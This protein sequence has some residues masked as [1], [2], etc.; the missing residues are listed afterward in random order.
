MPK[1]SDKAIIDRTAASYQNT[2]PRP[3]GAQILTPDDVLEGVG[4]M[5]RTYTDAQGYEHPEGM[6]IGRNER[7]EG[8]YIYIGSTPDSTTRQNTVPLPVDRPSFVANQ[9]LVIGHPPPS[10]QFAAKLPQP[11]APTVTTETLENVGYP[12]SSEARPYYYG[13]TFVVS[14]AHTALSPL[15]PFQLGEGQSFRAP[16]PQDVPEGVTKIGLWISEPGQTGSPIRGIMRLQRVL[17]ITL[18]DL[19]HYDFTGPYRY[20]ILAPEENE[21]G[22]ERPAR[23]NVGFASLPL[24]CKTGSY[25]FRVTFT[26][27]TGE[28]LPSDIAGPIFVAS[29]PYWAGSEGTE[30]LPGSGEWW[31]EMP[32]APAG[33]TGW[34]PY[35]LT[36]GEWNRVYYPFL[37]YGQNKPFPLDFL[38]VQGSGWSSATDE[39]G[40]FAANFLVSQDFPE[41]DT[42]R[43]PDP[44]SALEAPTP[45]GASVPPPGNYYVRVTEVARGLETIASPAVS[46]DVASGEVMRIS[47]ANSTNAVSNGSYTEV[48]VNGLP[49]GH[50][51]QQTNGFASM[52]PG[53]LVIGTSGSVAQASTAPSSTT[54]PIQIDTSQ[55]WTATGKFAIGPPSSGLLS[56]TLEVVLREFDTTGASVDTVLFSANEIGE[57]TYQADIQAAGAPTGLQWLADTVSAEIVHRI[58]STS[59]VGS[60]NMQVTIFDNLLTDHDYQPRIIHRDNVVD[61]S[62]SSAAGR[63]IAVYSGIP[64]QRPIVVPWWWFMFN[65]APSGPPPGDSGTPV[66]YNPPPEIPPTIGPDIIVAPPPDPI[67]PPEPPP[68]TIY[69]YP[70]PDL[71]R[72]AGLVRETVK[73][74]AGLPAAP[75]TLSRTPADS[76][77]TLAATAGELV[78]KDTGSAQS[79]S[80]YL[81]KTFD[82][83]GRHDFGLILENVMAPVLPNGGRIRIAELRRPSDHQAFLWVDLSTEVE[84]AALTIHSSP[85]DAGS[86]TLSLSGSLVSVAVVAIKEV[87][88]LDITGAPTS[89]GYVGITLDDILHYVPIGAAQYEQARFTLGVGPNGYGGPATTGYITIFLNN[90]AHNIAVNYWETRDQVFERIR[91]TSYPSWTVTT[92]TVAYQLVFTRGTAGPTVDATYSAGTTSMPG[93]MAT[94]TQGALESAAQLSARIRERSFP[95]WTVSGSGTFV[96]FTAV[97]AGDKTG[98]HSFSAL[99][100]GTTGVISLNTQG[101]VDTPDQLAARIRSA[102]FPAGWAVSGAGDTANI[103][104]NT[105]GPRQNVDFDAGGTG[106]TATMQ[107]VTQGTDGDLVASVQTESGEIMTRRVI[108]GLTTT[109]QFNLELAVSGAG[110]DKASVAAWGSLGADERDLV[111]FKKDLDLSS[112][113]AGAVAFGSS[114]ESSAALTWELRVGQVQITE[115]GSQFYR[116]HNTRGDVLNQWVY[117]APPTQPVR[118]DVGIQ[119][120]VCAVIPGKTYTA[121]VFM[122]YSSIP[123]IAQPLYAQFIASTGETIPLGCITGGITG[124]ADWDEATLTFTVP[125]NCPLLFISSRSMGPGEIVFQELAISV[126]TEVRRT[127]GYASTGYYRPTYSIATPRKFDRNTRFGPIRKLLGANI[128]IPEDCDATIS[129]RSAPMHSGPFGPWLS[130]DSAVVDNPVIQSHIEFSGTGEATPELSSGHPFSEYI[131]SDRSQNMP[132]TF[133]KGDRTELDGGAIFEAIE[134]YTMRPEIGV[135]R[136]PGG[137]VHRQQTYAPVGY[138]PPSNLYVFS[139]RARIYVEERWGTEPFC[140]EMDGEYLL[141]KLSEQPEFEQST[142]SIRNADGEKQAVYVAQLAYC[143]VVQVGPLA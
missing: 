74:D 110:T 59:G 123:N 52:E 9:P 31:V 40:K 130:D 13:Y 76:T 3:T 134:D 34:Y 87:V 64:G 129:Y 100:T 105:S 24:P 99:G 47:F 97:V 62:L 126:G 94:L 142:V 14:E 124:S 36:D 16:L 137:R 68:L 39:W 103:V 121:G 73:F 22:L 89:G 70:E 125:E 98:T 143:E 35:V 42:S 8:R 19:D 65:G 18:Y 104:A 95:R 113:L 75:W 92:T 55:D 26:N 77:T 107:T 118:N 44:D 101:A 122:R 58:V 54:E 102:L 61:T 93:T 96:Q 11:D 112:W 138:V 12:G 111:W 63:P 79:A 51:V 69:P 57:H 41:T 106:V 139:K 38:R 27:G 23:P 135:R 116:V 81:S 21:T 46:V 117:Y 71:P 45:F 83:D 90:V 136:L 141:I 115:P 1:V 108:T 4:D 37:G 7:V 88:T 109:Q 49:L 114:F 72:S 120:L 82:P 128:D 67:D 119:F 91:A 131:I 5:V 132:A 15:V 133:L 6:V 86:V 66:T 33:A 60:K 48:D 28:T 85:T 2:H 80:S 56:G 30:D 10:A 140:I 25:A 50:D 53:A 78:V 127:Y 43:L 29:D 20:G 17:D 84:R 32:P